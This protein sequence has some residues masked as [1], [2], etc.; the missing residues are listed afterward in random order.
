[1]LETLLE[2]RSKGERWAGGATISVTAHTALIAAALYATAEARVQPAKFP[3][4]VRPIYFP[5]APLPVQSASPATSKQR[6]FDGHRL[7]FVAPD[8]DIKIAAV[9]I[10]DV[11]SK[12]G[13]FNPGTIGSSSEG[14]QESGGGSASALFRADQVEKQVELIPGNTT[15]RYPEVL[16]NSGVEGKVIAEFVVDKQGCAEEGSVRFVGSGNQLFEEAVRVA[17]RRMRFIP[18]E[19][20]G[21]KVRQ[22]VQ[23]PFVF[24]LSR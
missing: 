4:T 10:S 16:R 20:G 18:A 19:V 2:S 21:V 5:S 1:M 9:D 12:P 17:L 11:V 13:D 3:E 22:L 7:T 24:T 6:P 14:R 8:I 15:P 23:M